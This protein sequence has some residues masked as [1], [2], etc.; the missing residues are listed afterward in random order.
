MKYYLMPLGCQMNRSDAER[1]RTVLNSMGLQETDNEHAPEIVLM[2]II[3]CS[4]RQKAI[5]RVYGKIRN[6][7]KLKKTRPLLTFVTGCILD[8][9]REKFLKLFDF[10]FPVTEAADF[11][12]MLLSSGIVMPFRFENVSGDTEENNER[13]SL[14]TENKTGELKKITFPPQTLPPQKNKPENV[15]EFWKI[16]PSYSSGSEAFVPIQNGCDKFCTY[17]AVPYTRGRE[18]SRDSDDILKEVRILAEDGYRSITLL[19]QNVNSYGLDRNG[20][21]ITF[22]QLMRRIGEYGEK[23]GLDF[24]V[25]FT[26][27]HPKDMSRELLEVIADYK[28]LAKWIH[29]PLQSGDDNVLERMNRR[30]TME[31]YR[32][33]MGLIRNIL[34]EAPVFTDIIVGFTGE[35]EEEFMH[36]ADAM[37]EFKYDMAFIAK[38]SPRPG[39]KS[40]NWPDDVPKE[41]KERRY[42]YL[43]SVLTETAALLNRARIGTVRRVLVTGKDRKGVYLSGYTEGRI[44]VRIEMPFQYTSNLSG[45]FADLLVTGASSLSLHGKLVSKKNQQNKD[46]SNGISAYSAENTIKAEIFE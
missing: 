31:R 14:K 27:P 1:L 39:A 37:R 29:L 17:C 30:H 5:D 18:V 33:L 36:T 21:E 11:P 46:I 42:R 9:D 20:N 8:S 19:G 12:E 43:S 13:K 41:E 45:S 26:S 2:G 10:V 23:S 25:Y 40:S 28:V 35:T 3:S 34:P 44:P 32:E 24:R 15:K 22:P 16:S 6:W 38:Y 7:N 4:V